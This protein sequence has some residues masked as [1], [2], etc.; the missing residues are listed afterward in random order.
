MPIN[1]F[2]DTIGEPIDYFVLKFPAKTA[3]ML[4]FITLLEADEDYTIF[5]HNISNRM[6]LAVNYLYINIVTHTLSAFM[7][8]FVYSILNLVP[9][10][11]I[12]TL[13]HFSHLYF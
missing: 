9:R 11:M 5:D 8:V 1:F 10:F 4:G 2:W 6:T 12:L 13:I 3:C 7:F